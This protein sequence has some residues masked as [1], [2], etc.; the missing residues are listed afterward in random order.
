MGDGAHVARGPEQAGAVVPVEAPQL[1][2]GR[3][4]EQDLG[5]PVPQV[6][7]DDPAVGQRA[8]VEAGAGSGRD[9][10]GLDAVGQVDGLGC[11]DRGFVAAAGG[12]G[13]RARAG[14]RDGGEGGCG[15]GR[16]EEGASSQGGG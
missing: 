13:R 7:G 6:A 8:D 14:G 12:G 10:L 5:R 3:A 9:A 1:P 11:L 15:R 16:A 2:A 4:L